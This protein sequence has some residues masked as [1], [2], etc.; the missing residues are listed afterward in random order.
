[1][2]RT[3]IRRVSTKSIPYEP[4]PKNKYNQVRSAY[5]FKP[6]KNDG[7]VYSPPAA[8]IKPQMITPYI[9]L[10]END[11]RRELAKQHRIDPK[12]VAE[13]PI[14]RQINALT[15]DNIMLMQIQLIKLKN[16]EL[17]ILNV[18]H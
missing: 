3:S 18:G 14:I 7:F 1:M 12:I 6:A 15:K 10:P 9:F 16:Y 2:I 4:I 17:L 8:I 5:N 13:M 11:P